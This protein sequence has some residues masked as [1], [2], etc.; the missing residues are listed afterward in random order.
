MARGVLL[1]N[2]VPP[3][4]SLVSSRT[5]AVAGHGQLSR[6]PWIGIAGEMTQVG[7]TRPHI[8]LAGEANA[9]RLIEAVFPEEV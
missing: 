4:A 6:Q 9:A 3:Q 8:T 1:L 7:A 5:V 2:Q